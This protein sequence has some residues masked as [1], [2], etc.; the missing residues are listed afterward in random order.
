MDSARTAVEKELKALLKGL[1]F[2]KRGSTWHRECEEVIQVINLQGSQ[3]S[4]AFYINLGVYVR[5]LGE[6]CYPRECFCHVRS[7]LSRLAR[8]APAEL[9]RDG[10]L[11]DEGIAAMPASE[12]GKLVCSLGI[13]WLNAISTSAGIHSYLESSES[14]HSAILLELRDYLAKKK[15]S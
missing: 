12:V 6:E 15:A 14:A 2:S 10:T 8:L 4:D 13:P 5:C 11:S 7:R 1:S 3:W 9:S